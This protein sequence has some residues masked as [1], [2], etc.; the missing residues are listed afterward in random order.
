M[1]FTRRSVL[2]TSAAGLALGAMAPAAARAEDPWF[3]LSLAQ[4]SLHR[5]LRKG[6][7][8][9]LDFPAFTKRTFGIE[10]V[11]YVNQFFA[12]KA[13]DFGYLS[14][15]KKRAGD[16]GVRSLIIMVDGE[17]QLAAEDDAAR[18]KAIENHFRWVAA[19]AFLGCHSIRVNAAGQGE[20]DE[21]AARAADSLVRL[22]TLAEP[23]GINVIVENHGG[24]SSNGAWLADVMQRA[25]HPAVGTLP[26]FGN[27]RVSKD[28]QYD[29][30]QGVTEL[31]PFAKAVSAKSH[32]FGPD[33]AELHTDYVRMLE[34]VKQAGYRGYVGIEYE[35][36]ELSEVDGIQATKK[37][38]ERVRQA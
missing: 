8:D 12:D 16:H 27:F 37:L 15:L 29:R 3:R 30:Y 23:Y 34:I 35:G 24:R 14:E 6:E 18:R 20:A 19:A 7:L 26:D 21:M 33:G 11:E 38:L 4:W 5:T 2:S 32:D 1:T 36:R 17:G 13:G 25:D 22:A 9:N 31:M 10:A 28:E